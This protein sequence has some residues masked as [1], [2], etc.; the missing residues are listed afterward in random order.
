LWYAGRAASLA[1][2]QVQAGQL[3]AQAQQS[4]TNYGRVKYKNYHGG[5]DGWPEL[6]AQ[7]QSSPNPPAGFTV[8]PAPTPAEQV[9]MMVQ[10]KQPRQ[11]DFGEWQLVFTYGDQPTVDRVWNDIKGVNLQFVGKVVQASRTKLQLAATADAIQA[12]KAD[13]DVT[14]AAPIPA[15]RIPKTNSEIMIQAMPV[16]YDKQPYMMHMGQG[17]LLVKGAKKA[18]PTARRRRR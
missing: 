15:A 12:N 17:K 3:P 18:A 7:T 10:Q 8:K 14:M 9:S 13:V 16:S 2:Q 4:I 11:M 1:A 6:I 5:E